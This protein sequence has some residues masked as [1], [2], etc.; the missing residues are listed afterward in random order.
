MERFLAR[1]M[2]GIDL[3]W[4]GASTAEIR[5]IEALAG[6]P[7]PDFYRWF[8]ARMG[9]NMGALGYA[10]VDFSAA[11]ILA[12]YREELRSPDPRY[13]LIGY[14]DDPVVPMHTWYDLARPMRGDAL[15]LSRGIGDPLIQ[16]DFETFREQLAW[17]AMLNFRL[18][19]LPASCKGSFKSHRADVRAR[20]DQA[21]NAL[22]FE[23]P[24]PSGDFCGI[25][26]RTDAAMICS[27]TP[28][29]EPEKILF[30][31]LAAAN[32]GTMRRILG[33]IARETDLEVV[34]DPGQP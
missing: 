29:E 17:K 3:G 9:R 32:A 15:V 30:F 31:R 24:V 19:A 33:V 27:V 20:L 6:R 7:L 2:P 26:D 5:E 28:R 18:D 21:M 8:L 12:C 14:E 1:L 4:E 22:N 13:L 23:Q 11:R 10:S 16:L 25:F 34:I